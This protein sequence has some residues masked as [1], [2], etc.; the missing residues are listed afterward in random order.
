MGF[1]DLLRIGELLEIEAGG[2]RARTKLQEILEDD[3]FIV[4]QP[5]VRGVP[6]RPEP[7]EPLRVTFCREDGVYAFDAVMLS[8]F[9]KE[10]MRLCLFKP[11]TEIEQIQRRQYYRFPAVLDVFMEKCDDKEV[12][13]KRYRAKTIDISENA[14]LLTCFTSFHEGT[15]FD[16]KIKLS[17]QETMELGGT[18][19]RC[20][21]PLVK[22]DPYKM[23]IVFDEL[24]PLLRLK[25]RRYILEKQIMARKKEMNKLS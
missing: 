25:L 4:L 2:S 15:D 13:R 9:R 8:M 22:D 5:T 16:I 23:V 3:N 10:D 24:S 19:I 20:Q 17:E 21:T 11:V 1:R 7:D 18:V 12:E 14:M 6:L